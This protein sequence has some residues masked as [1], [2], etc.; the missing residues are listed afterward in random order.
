MTLFLSIGEIDLTFALHWSLDIWPVRAGVS[1]AY[2]GL[3]A[4]LLMVVSG[5]D[6]E[7]SCC[8]PGP[9]TSCVM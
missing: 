5:S 4:L 3:P 9:G 1:A 7:S 8:D 2:P 6:L